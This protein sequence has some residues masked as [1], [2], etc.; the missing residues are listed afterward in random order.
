[1]LARIKLKLDRYLDI[2]TTLNSFRIWRTLLRKLEVL[3]QLFSIKTKTS[4]RKAFNALRSYHPPTIPPEDTPEEQPSVI[5]PS[6]PDDPNKVVTQ[7]ICRCVR[8]LVKY[9]RVGANVLDV[10]TVVQKRRADLSQPLR[11]L[12]KLKAVNLS[13]VIP[14]SQE[15]EDG[16]AGAALRWLGHS[17]ESE[18]NTGASNLILGR[19]PNRT[20]TMSEGVARSRSYAFSDSVPAAAVASLCSVEEHIGLRLDSIRTMELEFERKRVS[21]TAGVSRGVDKAR[22]MAGVGATDAL[23]CHPRELSARIRSSSSGRRETW[24][25]RARQNRNREWK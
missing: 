7:T 22:A 23:P 4:L 24:D 9:G 13:P 17:E 20:A 18:G 10:T 15:V 16:K 5:E 12:S 3:F 1:M 21:R 8:C 11:A 25:R 2:Q 19:S 14:E 6:P